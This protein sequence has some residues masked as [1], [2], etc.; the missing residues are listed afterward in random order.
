MTLDDGR[1]VSTSADSA[2]FIYIHGQR[3]LP[4]KLEQCITS[5]S[6]FAAEDVHGPIDP[7]AF[8]SVSLTE[9]PEAARTAG[10]LP[11]VTDGEGKTQQIRVH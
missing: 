6:V 1:V 2:P 4:S 7:G 11:D 10:S 8:R 5:L 9:I 3:Q